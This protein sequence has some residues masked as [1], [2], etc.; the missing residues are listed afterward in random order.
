M[1]GFA[2]E[3]NWRKKK[4][5]TLTVNSWMLFSMTDWEAPMFAVSDAKG[6]Y[7]VR[8]YLWRWFIG[9]SLWNVSPRTV[10]RNCRLQSPSRNAEDEVEELDL[11]RSGWVPTGGLWYF[12][13]QAPASFYFQFLLIRE[14]HKFID[15]YKSTTPFKFFKK[16]QKI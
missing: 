8:L 7:L 13:R 11:L 12:Q 4:Y 5:K 2:I 14:N 16:M 6:L 15:T 1:T 3:L 9:V 10:H